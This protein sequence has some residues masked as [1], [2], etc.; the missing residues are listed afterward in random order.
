VHRRLHMLEAA[1]NF[2]VRAQQAVTV[3]AD[4]SE[5]V[6][7]LR[8]LPLVQV[9][10][11]ENARAARTID[12][13]SRRC[14]GRDQA[15]RRRRATV[16]CATSAVLTAA[17]DYAAAEETLVEADA[18]CADNTVG[19]ALRLPRGAPQTAFGRE[20]DRRGAGLAFDLD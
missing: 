5:L 3:I 14:A 18:I 1:E 19:L 6:R 17:G 20:N 8:D 13:A 15:H 16:L 10:R 12:E 7:T 4:E 9:L 11:N 2:L